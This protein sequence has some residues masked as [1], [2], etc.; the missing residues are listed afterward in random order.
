MLA[1]NLIGCAALV[2]ATS[3]GCDIDSPGPIPEPQ[4]NWGPGSNT[5]YEPPAWDEPMGIVGD[6]FGCNNLDCSDLTNDGL[7]F[8]KDGELIELS[9]PG[10]AL[11]PGERYCEGN[12]GGQYEIHDNVVT[13]TL[14]NAQ[15]V[16][17]LE[18]SIDGDKMTLRAPG[19]DQETAVAKR[20]RPPRSDGPCPDLGEEPPVRVPAG[21]APAPPPGG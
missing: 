12:Q 7:R 1:R 10:S 13:L 8:T 9:A 20:I 16:L 14:G 5:L 21:P 18:F 2:A 15:A 6:W 19:N 4:L 17:A 11:E 3:F